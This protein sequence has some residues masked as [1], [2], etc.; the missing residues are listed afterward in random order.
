MVAL[1]LI[2]MTRGDYMENRILLSLS[3]NSVS[4]IGLVIGPR[5]V[6]TAFDMYNGLRKAVL[7]AT[8][9]LCKVF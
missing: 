7:V 6:S 4:H 9:L 1:V 3:N 2:L 8:I 5:A